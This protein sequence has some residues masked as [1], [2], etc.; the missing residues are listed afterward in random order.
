MTMRARFWFPLVAIL[1]AACFSGYDTPRRGDLRVRRATF[2]DD[3]LLTG[4]LESA[5]GATIAVPA[6]P[7]WQ[8][9]I[10]WLAGDG[11][12]VKEGERV[13]ELDNTQFATELDSKK[14]AATQA[15]HELQQKEP[16][17]S[18]DLTEKQL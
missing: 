10:K 5:R 13:A 9:S 16:E 11:S 6:L 18:V 17:W 3:V 8:T 2:A 4:E 12:E 7:Q 15:A 1:V 14:Q